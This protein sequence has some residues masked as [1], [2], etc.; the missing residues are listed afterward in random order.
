MQPPMMYMPPAMGVPG[1]EQQGDYFV[2][3]N[4]LLMQAHYNHVL[5]HQGANGFGP[6]FFFPPPGTPGKL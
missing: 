6:P 3:V 4:P 1:M 5:A 2:P